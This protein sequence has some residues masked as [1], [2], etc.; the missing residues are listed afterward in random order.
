MIGLRMILTGARQGTVIIQV[1][2]GVPSGHYVLVGVNLAGIV[3]ARYSDLA[4][5]RS[6]TSSPLAKND[7]LTVQGQ[8]GVD[9]RTAVLAYEAMCAT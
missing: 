9:L 5:Q 6:T 1:A 4:R 8:P 3:Y 2:A 7:T